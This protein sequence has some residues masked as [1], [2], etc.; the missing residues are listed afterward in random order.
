MDDSV[1]TAVQQRLVNQYQRMLSQ[2]ETIASNNDVEAVHRY[3]VSLRKSRCLLAIFADELANTP[4]ATL[5]ASFKQQAHVS[6][7]VRDIDVFIAAVDIPMIIDYLLQQRLLLQQQ[8][9]QRLGDLQRERQLCLSCLLLPWPTTAV[10]LSA[11]V[12][13][14]LQQLQQRSIAASK[15]AVSTGKDKHWHKLRLLI[16]AQRYLIELC[17]DNHHSDASLWQQ[18]LGEFNDNCN[19]LQFLT[20]LPLQPKRLQRQLRKLTKRLKQQKKQQKRELTVLV[21]QE[22]TKKDAFGLKLKNSS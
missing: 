13:T 8:L 18:R 20:D 15:L 5:A 4:A 11:A 1:V 9:R 3:R 17:L 6:N 21:E 14:Q 19:Q 7:A 2:V 22:L 10:T 12:A 16:K